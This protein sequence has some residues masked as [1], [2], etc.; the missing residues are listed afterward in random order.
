MPAF[1]FSFLLNFIKNLNLEV[2]DDELDTIEFKKPNRIQEEGPG[3]RSINQVVL[4]GRVGTD[5]QIR[6]S[7]EK[8]ITTFTMATNSMWKTQNPGPGDKA[9][10]N[11]VEWHNV[12]VFKPG[13]REYV[14]KFVQK[15]DYYYYR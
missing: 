12:V 15:V 14:Y 10:Q 5:P 11:Y 6:G 3:E 8:P 9:W 13:L 4:M 7:E 1:I 2:N